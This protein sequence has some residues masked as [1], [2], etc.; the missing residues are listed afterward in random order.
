[1]KIKDYILEKEVLRVSERLEKMKEIRAPK[2]IIEELTKNL[3]K[4][5]SGEIKVGGEIE[6]LEEEFKQHEVK[7]GRDG[8]P[9]IIFDNEVKYFPFAKYG[10]YITK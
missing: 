2:V 9:Y 10:R 8:V 3:V 1:M 7:H 5:Q 6:L 4:I